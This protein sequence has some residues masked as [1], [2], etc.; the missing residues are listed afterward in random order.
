MGFPDS[1][2]IPVSDTQAYKQFG[3]SIVVPVVK[4][5]AE[6]MAA[7]LRGTPLPVRP[8]G[9]QLLLRTPENVALVLLIPKQGR[10]V[11]FRCNHS[12]RKSEYKKTM[13]TLPIPPD[14][15]EAA[16]R[17]RTVLRQRC[18]LQISS[19]A[20]V[21]HRLGS[22]R[23]LRPGLAPGRLCRIRQRLACRLAH[24]LPRKRFDVPTS[25]N[26]PT[27]SSTQLKRNTPGL[28]SAR[29]QSRLSD[30]SLSLAFLSSLSWDENP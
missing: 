22:H 26:W 9:E 20:R 29:S 15:I 23:L 2:Q 1:F 14:H 18:R 30:R 17:V 28:A 27:G 3:N 21:P 7:C 13:T 25:A 19:K 24:S 10:G 5:I 11:S 16:H 4:A 6:A 12:S 8:T